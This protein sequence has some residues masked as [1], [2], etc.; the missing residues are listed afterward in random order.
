M[1]IH[2]P[3]DNSQYTKER[4]MRRAY[5]SDR[6]EPATYLKDMSLNANLELGDFGTC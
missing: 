2:Y 4:R 1:A 5:I 3:N 6:H